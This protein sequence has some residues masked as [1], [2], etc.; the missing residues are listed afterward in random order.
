LT[1][2]AKRQ[3][4]DTR[5]GI[6]WL[7]IDYLQPEIF[8]AL[9]Y[10]KTGAS[11][12]DLLALA[13]FD[14]PKRSHICQLVFSGGAQLIRK[15]EVARSGF[16]QVVYNSPSCRFGD[17][18]LFPGGKTINLS[19]ARV[20]PKAKSLLAE[21]NIRFRIAAGPKE[22]FSAAQKQLLQRYATS[23]N[24]AERQIAANALF[25]RALQLGQQGRSDLAIEVY[26]ELISLFG[27]STEQD[28]EE[29]VA[30]SL[31]NRGNM[32]ADLG[33]GDEA[34]SAYESVINRFDA[35]TRPQV[36]E[37]VARSLFNSARILGSRPDQI[38]DAIGFYRQIFERFKAA[39]QLYP[40]EIVAK[41][42]VNL[43]GLLVPTDDAARVFD[44]VIA[45]FGISEEDGLREQVEKALANKGSVLM[46]NGRPLEALA[47][48]DALLA[49][50][51]KSK[52]G[53]ELGVTFWKMDA[54][55]S[56]GRED[57][58]LELC[59]RTMEAIGPT[60][61]KENLAGALLNKASVLKGRRNFSGELETYDAL[62]GK[63][64]LQDWPIGQHIGRHVDFVLCA[65]D[66]CN[67]DMFVQFSRL[68][69]FVAE[70]ASRKGEP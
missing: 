28:L 66:Q 58:A 29:L 6:I 33:R 56:L 22:T 68:I 30:A 14:S 13:V 25:R 57:E 47:A 64:G 34:L 61:V 2:T 59:D 54:L 20:G 11:F 50:P 63:Y 15:G 12:L 19:T 45:Y 69:G 65:I 27:A 3:F 17:V 26:D 18:R 44:E 41:A 62:I 38:G 16:G 37:K 52:A 4:T 55:L 5:P 48:L 8:D 67:V 46:S 60:S 9:A 51:E 24:M 36:A 53:V 39:P 35:A 10:A 32:L 21:A 42:L 1:D 31:F 7:H 40:P 43:G 49:R 23:T 70:K